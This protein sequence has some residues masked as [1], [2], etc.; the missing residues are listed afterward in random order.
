MVLTLLMIIQIMG[1]TVSANPV[2]FPENKVVDIP[3]AVNQ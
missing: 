1:M 2:G 3:V